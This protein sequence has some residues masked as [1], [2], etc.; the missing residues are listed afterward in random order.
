MK[1]K[2][3]E[4]LRLDMVCNPQ[5]EGRADLLALITSCMKISCARR[6]LQSRELNASTAGNDQADHRACPSGAWLASERQDPWSHQ[7][8]DAEP[9]ICSF[10]NG[11]GLAERDARSED[12]D[13]TA[14]HGVPRHGGATSQ[15]DPR[16][17]EKKGAKRQICPV[18]P[19]LG[20][21]GRSILERA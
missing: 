16:G 10:R 8:P 21:G 20:F 1:S 19:R 13:T 7:Q 12:D 11:R 2:M 17:H 18:K 9:G 15:A 5:V 4:L 14:D 6:T 3:S